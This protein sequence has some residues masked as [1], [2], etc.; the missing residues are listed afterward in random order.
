LKKL[1]QSGDLFLRCQSDAISGERIRAADFLRACGMA[2]LQTGEILGW[3]CCVLDAQAHSRVEPR[4]VP[5]RAGRAADG[6]GSGLA[7]P[8]ANSL[9]IGLLIL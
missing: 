2:G 5:S 7:G 1:R 9:A 4:L 6:L 8:D 3:V